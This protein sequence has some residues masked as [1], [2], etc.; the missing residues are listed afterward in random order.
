MTDQHDEQRDGLRRQRKRQ[1]EIDCITFRYTEEFRQGRRPRIEDYVQRY[2]QYASEL[3]DFAV[4]FHTIGF[5]VESLE[6]PA[7]LT[8]S[9]AAEKALARIRERSAAY[10]PD[11]T[12]AGAPATSATPITS[13]SARGMDLKLAPPQ[14]AEAVGLTFDVLAKIEAR[15]ITV[16]SIPRTLV[17]RLAAA[18][19]TAPEAIAA[20]IS[21]APAGQ[22]GGFYYADQAPSQQQES[23]LDAVQAS[24]LNPDQ[25]REWADIVKNESDD[26]G[27][28]P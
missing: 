1:Y 8:L 3:L 5:E 15:A 27:A 7:E 6:E 13:L 21:G 16:S 22:A 11:A 12:S 28:N 9:P 25:K 17:Q 24:A 20:Y 2:P 23:F 4:Y 19:K 26:S 10:A 14:L 18:L